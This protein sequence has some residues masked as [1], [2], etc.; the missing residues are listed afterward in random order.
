MI[1]KATFG[2]GCFWSVQA[3]FDALAGVTKTEVGY[4]GGDETRFP[5]PS[6]AQVC[7]GETGYAEVV[8]IWYDDAKVA[9]QELLDVFWGSH[10]S[11]TRDRQ[12]PD[13]GSQYRSLIFYYTPEQ[14]KLAIE[15]KKKMQQK[16]GKIVVTELAPATT[17]FKAEEY[18][19]KYL[20]KRGMGSCRI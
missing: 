9:Y 20:V 12:G 18:H 3:A 7:T 14:Q 2:A 16:L 15:S 19:Q 8:C 11:T 13:I 17:F 4:M 5:K 10:D 1:Q 6:Y